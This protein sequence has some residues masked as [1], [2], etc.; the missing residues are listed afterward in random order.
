MLSATPVNNRFND[1]KNQLALAYEGYAKNI[2]DK[3]DTERGVDE[4]FKRAQTAFN[5]WSK[6]PSDNRLLPGPGEYGDVRGQESASAEHAGPSGDAARGGEDL[7]AGLDGA[8]A[9]GDDELQPPT[10]TRP[11]RTRDPFRSRVA[12]DESEWRSD[13]FGILDLFV[14][15][16]WKRPAPS[17]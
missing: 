6:F 8:R 13:D 9:G 4:I 10:S 14:S 17:V 1:L 15:G 2:D 7:V 12:G 11:R 5:I 16:K 3:L